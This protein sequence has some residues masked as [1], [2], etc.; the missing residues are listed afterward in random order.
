MG[1]RIGSSAAEKLN[2][3]K[4]QA[5]NTWRTFPEAVGRN[6]V[7]TFAETVNAAG[8]LLSR[9]HRQTVVDQLGP[10]MIRTSLLLQTL[11]HED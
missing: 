2:L 3:F 10:A 4:A 5:I 11:A 8:I 7:I 6:P 1:S 9:Q